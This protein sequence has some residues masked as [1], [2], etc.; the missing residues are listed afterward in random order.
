MNAAETLIRLEQ[1]RAQAA[2]VNAEI[3]ALEEE[4]NLRGEI[5]R[6]IL[7]KQAALRLEIENMTVTSLQYEG[8]IGILREKLEAPTNSEA[9]NARLRELLECVEDRLG[10]LTAAICE[11]R[12]QLAEFEDTYNDRMASRRADM[13]L[14]RSL[15]GLPGL[16]DVD[17]FD[18]D[19]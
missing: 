18:E 8:T 14:L 4:V 11:K 12:A 5:P 13:D 10:D 7:E 3:A 16:E 19:E 9:T 2:A 1:L 6:E 17:F 15:I